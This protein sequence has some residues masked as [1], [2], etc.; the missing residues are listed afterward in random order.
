MKRRPGPFRFFLAIIAFYVL[1]Y[2]LGLSPR[3]AGDAAR[4]WKPPVEL[5]RKAPPPEPEVAATQPEPGVPFSR[6]PILPGS[7]L[8]VAPQMVRPETR[9]WLHIVVHHSAGTAGNAAEFDRMHREE[10]KWEF[11]LGY[12]FVVGNGNGAPAGGVEI[13]QRWIDQ[14]HGAHAGANATEY[15][16]HGIGICVVGNYDE[17]DMPEAV[18]TGLRDLV[19]WLAK[20]YSIP[21][22]NI[23]PHRDVRGEPTACPGKNFPLDR[24]RA[25]VLEALK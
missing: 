2:G 1:A 15:N 3:P 24:L 17:A 23:L 13:G 8:A 25:D 12:H 16:Q 14:R 18:Y 20:R 10:N 22:G 11:G 21:P 6:V 5:P 7:L 19:A 4:A 9:E